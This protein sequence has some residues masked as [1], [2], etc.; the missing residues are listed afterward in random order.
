[1]RSPTPAVVVA[2]AAAL[3]ASLAAGCDSPSASTPTSVAPSAA[4]LRL[5]PSTITV[6]EAVSL[7]G[8]VDVTDA[9]GDFATLH[10]E[11]TD[12]GGTV[13]ALSLAIPNPSQLTAAEVPFSLDLTPAEAGAHVLAAWVEDA[14]GQ[15]S[16]RVTATVTAVA[17]VEPDLTSPPKV[18]RVVFDPKTVT[19]GVEAVLAGTV[20]V[21]D[22][23]GDA[24]ALYVQVQGPGGT[25]GP[26]VVVP[27]DLAGA[28][29]AT[30]SFSYPFTASA[31]G[32]HTLRFH[33]VD[34]TEKESSPASGLFTASTPLPSAPVVSALALDQTAITPGVAVTLTGTVHVSDDN[35]DAATLV[36]RLD[37][38]L[39]SAPPDVTAAIDLGGATAGTVAFEVAIASPVAGTYGVDVWALDAGNRR[40]N[41]VSGEVVA[42][43]TAPV[44]SALSV[45]PQSV[46]VD[47]ETTLS[48]TVTA[49]DPTGDLAAVTLRIL[50]PGGAVAVADVDVPLAVSG[51]VHAFSLPFTPT[52]TG[53]WL[54]EARA[55]DEE[56]ATS[57]ARTAELTVHDLSQVNDACA[58]TGTDCT[59]EGFCYNVVASTCEYITSR[60]LSLDACADVPE[61]TVVPTC[62]SSISDLSSPWAATDANCDFVQY[63]SNPTDFPIDCRCPDASLE[64]RCVRPYNLPA[65]TSFGDG[66]RVRDLATTV[67]LYNGPII[68]REWFVPAGWSTFNKPDQT[69]IFAIDIDTGARRRVSGAY[70]DPQLGT[71]VLGAGPELVNVLDMKLG[72]D[73]QLYAMGGRSDIAP[74]KVWRIDPAT[75]DRTLLFDEETADEA[76]LCPN[77]S[78]LAGRKTVQMV[79][80]GWAMDADGHHYFAVIGTPGPSIVRMAPDFSSCSYLTRVTD[81]PSTTLTDNVGTG[82]DIVQFDFRAFEIAGGSLFAVSD[83]K[84]IEVSLADGHRTLRSNAK[85]VGGL[86]AGPI[87]AEGLGHRWSRWDAERDVLWTVG[88]SGGSLAVVV[89]LDSGDRTAWPCWHPTLGLRAAC[90]N[91]GIALVP[92][93]LNFGGFAIDPAPPHDLVFAHDMFSIVRY[94][95][96]TGNAYILSL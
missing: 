17:A 65:A 70:V 69:I 3:L 35:G 11:M 78:T 71:T 52:E 95:V 58:A 46:L 24:A 94:E 55:S 38:P 7:S 83:T 31:S 20:D 25:T 92:G 85:E 43:A 29:K 5:T 96:K 13:G 64:D 79:P 93:P 1:M 37:P 8:R 16:P 72:G 42:S 75:G 44:V 10:L 33:A 90:D 4:N 73:G 84:L 60:G 50:A 23:D 87:N 2:A 54:L 81:T 66:P 67:H 80:E 14:T 61:D 57:A 48:G 30:V 88:L 82:Y 12:P 68:G 28:T 6:G 56:G 9:D 19:V 59:G 34:A 51:D 18:E 41:T 47:V 53:T 32:S 39:G 77:G 76:T 91:V 89:D 27:V 74:P 36:V 15:L 62:V 86:G 40:S 49:S 63:W 26:E 45:Q 21:S 22:P